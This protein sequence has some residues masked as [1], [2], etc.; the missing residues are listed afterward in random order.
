MAAL[1]NANLEGEFAFYGADIEY[2]QEEFAEF[3]CAA[4][5]MGS[6]SVGRVDEVIIVIADHGDAAAGGRYD[7]VVAAKD[8]DEFGSE[9][10]CFVHAT[11]VGHGLAAAGLGFRKCCVD[12]E[13]F[14][15]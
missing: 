5:D 8:I 9:G 14:E 10:L 13:G 11:A 15:N 4:A 12:A 1:V 2:L 6:G 3:E 7:V